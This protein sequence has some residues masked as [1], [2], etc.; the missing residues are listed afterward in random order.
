[1]KPSTR[2]IL[3]V[4]VVLLLL[5]LLGWLLRCSPAEPRRAPDGPEPA[6]V[7]RAAPSETSEADEPEER[8]TPA[9]LQAPSRVD[10][11]AV[12]QVGWSGPDNPR[13]YVTIVPVG[14]PDGASGS[15]RDTR[16][17]PSLELTAPIEP[18]AFEV[19][20]VTGRSRVVLGR[21]AVTVV[22]VGATLDAAA[23]VVLGSSISVAWTGPDNAGDYVTLVPKGTADGRFG[24]YTNTS[25]GSPLAV[26]APTEPG[27]AELRYMTGQGNRVL[28]RRPVTIVAAEVTLSAPEQA[29]AGSTVQVVWTGPGN[30][31]DYVTVVPAGTP[32]GQYGNY[33]EVRAGSPLPLLLPIPPGEAELRYMTGQGAKVLGRRPI[34]V[35][36]AVITL[37]APAEAVA[38][39]EVTIAWTGPDHP[40]DYITLI[41]RDAAEG[42]YGDYAS[43]RDGSPSIVS[44]PAEAGEAEVRYVSGQGARVLAR[45]P[46][47]I[48]P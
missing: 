33:A 27:E 23:E 2:R 39:S 30:P 29:V 21:A 18:G 14:A 6:P 20:Y 43:T 16:E 3:W 1:M 15:Y 19:R 41:E 12:F 47:R 31:G 35:V 17:G 44:A 24:N 7:E 28:A 34:R 32:D 5:L 38:G 22:A 11:G 46:I 40:G 26:V 42:R 45:R 9:S 4:V 36:A 8:R 10:A 25:E 13:D 48:V 37:D